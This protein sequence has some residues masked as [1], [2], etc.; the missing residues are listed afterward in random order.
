MVGGRPSDPSCYRSGALPP[1]GA[2]HLHEVDYRAIMGKDWFREAIDRL[3]EIACEQTTAI[4][5]SEE[6]AARCHRHHLIAR[7]L[8]DEHPE[9]D[10]RHIRGDVRRL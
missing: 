7:Y 8:L 4:M 10:V 5:C 6:D 3:L 2:D 1:E 9:I